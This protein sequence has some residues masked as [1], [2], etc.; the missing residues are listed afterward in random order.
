[1]L[2]AARARKREALLQAP[3]R[4]RDHMVAAT[5]RPKRRVQGQDK[6]GWRVGRVLQRFKVATHFLVTITA[7]SFP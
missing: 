4:E 5:Q 7:A 2:A 1:V 6:M 3:E